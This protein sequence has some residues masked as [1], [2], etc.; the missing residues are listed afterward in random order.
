MKIG[1]AF[2]EREHL[3]SR[4]DALESRLRD[5]LKHGR[6]VTH[7]IEEIDLASAR[8]LALQDAIDWT[9]QHLLV[10]NKALG[11]HVNK[12]NHYQRV[13]DLLEEVA[14]PDLRERVDQLYE[15]KK[16]T[17]VLIQTIKWAYDLQIPGE[18]VSDQPEEED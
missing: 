15:A 4:L 14:S 18:E 2:L 8:A 16:S 13:A 1:E 9:M 12:L 5:D 6:P 17:E 10:S 7:V 11:A 3:N